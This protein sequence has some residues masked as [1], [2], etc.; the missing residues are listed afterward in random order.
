MDH[1]P[2]RLV[3]S[4]DTPFVIDHPITLDALLSAAVFRKTGL[5]GKD[6][7]PH[8]PLTRER[9]IF[10]AS[11]LSIGQR[12]KHA[13]VGRIMS[14]RTENDLSVRLFAPNRKRGSGYMHIDQKR[15][16]YKANMSSYGGIDAHEVTFHAV[17][18]PE[19]CIVLIQ[20]YI[21][22]IGKRSNAGAGQISNVRYELLSESGRERAWK[23][24]KGKPARPLPKE[25]WQSISGDK[26]PVEPLTVDVPYWDGQV[27]D[28]VFPPS[29]VQ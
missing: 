11:S 20:N 7:I 6:T 24:A 13:K 19:A 1:V 21:L 14:L 3:L 18:D 22:G 2:F 15:G 4:I 25:L 12:Y 9:G 26:S 17:G 28:A 29:L 5:I 16:Q 8:I 27:C 23:T 10:L